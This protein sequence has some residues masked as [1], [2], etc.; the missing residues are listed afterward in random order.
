MGQAL[1]S[2][3]SV[4]AFCGIPLVSG[5]LPSGTAA[6][7]LGAGS[8]LGSAHDGSENGPFFLRILSKVHTWA[9]DDPGVFT[10]RHG[11]NAL[12]GIADLGD[13]DFT[14]MQLSQ[15]LDTIADAVRALPTDV[16]PCVIGGDHSITLPVVRV[17]AERRTE[18]F[19][20]VQFDH[21]LDL[22]IWEAPPTTLGRS[23]SRSS[24]LM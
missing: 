5:D 22:Q 2:N 16:A 21:H 3:T 13:L 4:T 9:A 10:L 6:A 14:G 12:R 1:P 17:L 18:P 11:R 15:A 23:A 7:V 20:V 8:S 24:T 19:L